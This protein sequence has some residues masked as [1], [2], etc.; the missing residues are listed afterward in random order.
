MPAQSG[1]TV[2]LF[3]HVDSRPTRAAL[4]YFKERRVDVVFVDLRRRPIAPG[5]LRRF[6]ERLGAEALLDTEGRHYK[7]QGLAYMRLGDDEIVERL[8]ADNG[9]LK[10]PLVRFANAFTA[11]PADATWKV[12]LAASPK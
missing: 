10:L 6:V 8:L 12:W 2:Q 5:E 1:P 4:R 9:L 11:G 3:G 7:E